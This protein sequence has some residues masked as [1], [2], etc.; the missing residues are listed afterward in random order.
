MRNHASWTTVVAQD[1]HL[2]IS[3]SSFKFANCSVL[4]TAH[5]RQAGC[6]PTCEP[7]VDLLLDLRCSIAG[8]PSSSEREL[9]IAIRQREVA[10]NRKNR[11]ALSLDE[12]VGREMLIQS[13]GGSS[14]RQMVQLMPVAETTSTSNG[15]LR[16]GQT[17]TE[18]P[19][20]VFCGLL[21]TG[22]VWKVQSHR[23][24]PRAPCTGL[25][26]SILRRARKRAEVLE[27]CLPRRLHQCG[28]CGRRLRSH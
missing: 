17:H 16:H 1:H 23:R 25:V 4:S 9:H 7:D 15:A 24:L 11:L 21:R 28:R 2:P 6:P 22:Q 5:D 19:R 12:E 26:H 18:C 3:T 20:K 14:V 13:A 8:Q 10:R 27:A